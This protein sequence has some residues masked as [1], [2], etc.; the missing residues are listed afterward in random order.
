M[1]SGYVRWASLGGYPTL[2]RGLP[3]YPDPMDAPLI[4]VTDIPVAELASDSPRVAECVQR[5]L[6]SVNDG[7][8]ALSAFNSFAS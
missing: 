2:V 5:L 7:S 4:D 6:E 8:E 3:T 1:P